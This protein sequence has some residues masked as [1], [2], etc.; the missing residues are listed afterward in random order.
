MDDHQPDEWVAVIMQLG[1]CFAAMAQLL[2][3]RGVLSGE[4]ISELY[5][6]A[7]TNLEQ[8]RAENPASQRAN[9]LARGSIEELL[10]SFR[11]IRPE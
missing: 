4:D 10:R 2:V 7:L 8:A 5:E 6:I 11:G 1:A 3:A 9:D